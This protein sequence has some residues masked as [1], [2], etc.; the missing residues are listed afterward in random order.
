MKQKLLKTL[1]SIILLIGITGCTTQEEKQLNKT[2]HQEKF[3]LGHTLDDGRVIHFTF[4]VPY[5]S[6]S[7]HNAI[8]NKD[9]T[10]DEFL[11]QL[12]YLSMEN[13]GGSKLYKYNKNQKTF[14]DEDF[15]VISCNSIDNIKDIYVAKYLESINDK[16]LLKINDLE[17]VTMTIKEGTLTKTG[18]TVIITDTSNR[19]N[20]YGTPYRLDK[21]EN[22]EWKPLEVIYEGNYAWTAIGYLKD[23]NNK[24]EFTI[25]WK[26][27]YGELKKGKYRIVKDTSE[28]GEGTT[29]YITA[30]FIIE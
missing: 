1:I 14:G 12:N 17:G 3:M 22:S 11:N 24:L 4:D 25:N 20:I 19:E 29:H 6:D 8:V 26:T 18:A 30:E 16:C 23:E 13:D 21:F 10:I 28:S 15:Y 7:L 5:N 2:N 27:L 9:I